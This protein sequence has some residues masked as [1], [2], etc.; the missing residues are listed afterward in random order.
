MELREMTNKDLRNLFHKVK[1]EIER[2]GSEYKRMLKEQQNMK[3]INYNYTKELL[4][5]MSKQLGYDVRI[6]SRKREYVMFRHALYLYFRNLEN[7]KRC[8]ILDY[9]DL[10]NCNHS[11]IIFNSKTAQ[12]LK[13]TNHYDYVIAENR[14]TQLINQFNNLKQNQNGEQKSSK[15]TQQVPATCKTY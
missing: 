14:L 2:R 9:A 13:D 8:T 12:D 1:G 7:A 5:Y 4:E 10:L 6:K 3:N 15:S 11:T